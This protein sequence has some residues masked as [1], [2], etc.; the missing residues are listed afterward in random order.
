MRLF[1]N[2]VLSEV[3]VFFVASG[4]GVDRGVVVPSMKI[5]LFSELLDTVEQSRKKIWTRVT[6]FKI[7]VR[8]QHFLLLTETFNWVNIASAWSWTYWLAFHI[9]ILDYHHTCLLGTLCCYT[10]RFATSLRNFLF[11]NCLV[12]LYSNTMFQ[13]MFRWPRRC[14]HSTSTTYKI[15]QPFPSQWTN[16]LFFAFWLSSWQSAI[17]IRFPERPVNH[18][19]DGYIFPWLY[20]SQCFPR[21]K[22]T[23]SRQW[24]IF[25]GS[26][27]IKEKKDKQG[28]KFFIYLSLNFV[29]SLKN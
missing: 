16:R 6:R 12:L 1:V 2:W 17:L 11:Q 19:L 29:I 20:S 7:K 4:W 27:S 8:L 18:S 28:K 5:S 21:G 3:D 22:N 10:F 13:L 24:L 23:W 15:H 25:M 14:F 26:R 9:Y